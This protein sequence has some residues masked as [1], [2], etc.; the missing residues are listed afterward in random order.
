MYGSIVQTEITSANRDLLTC[1]FV[2]MRDRRL[3]LPPDVRAMREN[4]EDMVSFFNAFDEDGSKV[5]PFSC[6]VVSF[7]SNS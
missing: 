6:L 2:V 3:E 7:S 1:F 4:N 5:L